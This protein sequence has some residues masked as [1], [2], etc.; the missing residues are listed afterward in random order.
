MRA[1]GLDP[2]QD[3][4]AAGGHLACQAHRIEKTCLVRYDMIR[5]HHDENARGILLRD[6][7]GSNSDSARRVALHRLQ[8]NGARRRPVAFEVLLDQ[9]AMVRIAE[10]RRR[11]EAFVGLQ[12]F[13]GCAE[14]TYLAPIE[15]DELL[16]IHG[17]R[18]GPEP[19]PR[20]TGEDNGVKSAHAQTSWTTPRE[21]KQVSRP[22]WVSY[23]STMRP[24]SRAGRMRWSFGRRACPPRPHRSTRNLP[25][26]YGS[27]PP[28]QMAVQARQRNKR[29]CARLR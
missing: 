11:P 27:R 13:Q 7:Q 5:R 10:D 17:P 26:A 15:A 2:E 14:Q 18:Q 22:T 6:A 9:K 25:W 21:A 29:A 12:P 28:F 1:G 20:S 23:Q 19:R 3:Q 8:N 16:R 4:P 24:S